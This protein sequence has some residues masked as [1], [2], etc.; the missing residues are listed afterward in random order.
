MLTKLEKEVDGEMKEYSKS[1]SVLKVNEPNQ[2]PAF[3]NKVPCKEIELACPMY[4]T[5]VKSAC[6]AS[7]KSEN[8]KNPLLPLYNG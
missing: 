7:E 8:S 5:V 6:N 4:S 1:D 2:L 3:S